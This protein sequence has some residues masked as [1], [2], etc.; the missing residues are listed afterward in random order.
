TNFVVKVRVLRESYEDMRDKD[1]PNKSMFNPGMSATVDIM[2]K[3]VS[4]ILSIPIQAVTTRDT[5]L[6]NKEV[7][8]K[9]DDMEEDMD[10]VK[11]AEDKKATAAK[12]KEEKDK[13]TEC[14][15]VVDSGKVKLIPVKVGVQ[16]NNYIEIKEGLKDGQVVVAAPY[17]LIS[18]VLKD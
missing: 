16:D 6:K 13:K 2:T 18:R 5:S 4:D 17:S 11:V 7:K 10:K 9:K 1:H 15:F 12:E 8:G 3:R 14:V